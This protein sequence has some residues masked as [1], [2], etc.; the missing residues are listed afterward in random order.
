MTF[1][2]AKTPEAFGGKGEAGIFGP[3]S[4]FGTSASGSYFRSNVST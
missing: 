3:A 4:R 2:T 1:L